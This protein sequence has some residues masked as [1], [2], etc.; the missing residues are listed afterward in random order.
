MN[1][2]LFAMIII[3]LA[4]GVFGCSK[5]S[6]VSDGLSYEEY[7]GLA[8]DY[9]I[10]SDNEKAISAYKKALKIRPHDAN[11][12]FALGRLYDAEGQRSYTDAFNKYQIEILTNPDKKQKKD[13]TSRLIELGYKIQYEKYALQEYK[14]TIKYVP[15]HWAARYFIAT[16]HFNN[17]RYKEAIKEYKLVIE[18]NPKFKS[19]YKLLGE[20]CLEIGWCDMALDNFEKAYKLDSNIE[21]YYY[22]IGRVYMNKKNKDKIN[23]AINSLKGSQSY[24]EKLIDYQFEFHKSCQDQ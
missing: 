18:I 14:E 19:A 11:T 7:V 6:D 5:S 24:Y 12:H 15:E 2:K 23:E 17:K 21:S 22:N 8:Q 20:S 10:K 13:Q 3:T 16:D 1:D 9:E 4:I